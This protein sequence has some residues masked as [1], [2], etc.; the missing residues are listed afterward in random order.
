MASLDRLRGRD[1]LIYWPGHGGPVRNPQRFV[2]ALLHHRRQ[3]E[4][5]IL[6][7]L[8]KGPGTVEAIVVATY[9]TLDPRLRH[10]AGASVLAHLEDL[11]E[12]GLVS[13]D[14]SAYTVSGTSR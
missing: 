9:E 12:R 5:S 2:R 14:A 3:R 10:A 11:C 8:A 4:R 1:D 13:V 7:Q 6:A